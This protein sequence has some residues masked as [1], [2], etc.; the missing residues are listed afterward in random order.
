MP[1]Y[2]PV[3]GIRATTKDG[4]NQVIRKLHSLAPDA[5][6]IFVIRNQTDMIISTY[7][8]YVLAGGTRKANEFCIELL[9]CSSDGENYFCMF[10]D[11]L[12]EISKEYFGDRVLILLQENLKHDQDGQIAKLNAFIGLNPRLFKDTFKARRV[13]LSVIGLR[14]TRFLNLILAR[15]GRGQVTERYWVPKR[16]YRFACNLVRVVDYYLVSRVL[17]LS[18]ESLLDRE[19]REL[20]DSTFGSD[21]A[22]LAARL[23]QDLN[24]LGYNTPGSSNF[25]QV[26]SESF[27][28]PGISIYN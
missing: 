14:F 4:T 26:G 2:H 12:I 3:L 27:A 13:G 22:R 17:K 15:G 5:K 8:Q 18:K 23:G 10:F 6:L 21:N 16:V 9:R 1:F 19:A 28:K 11:E 20:I 25:E 24:E 7:S